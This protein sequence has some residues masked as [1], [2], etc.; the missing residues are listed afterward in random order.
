MRRRSSFGFFGMFGRSFDLR[1]LDAAL[2]GVDLH[3]AL[4][5]E[6]VKMT[7]VNLMKD[8]GVDE[9]EEAYPA[10]AE[11]FG[12]CVMGA[13]AFEAVNGGQRLAAV[14]ARIEKAL[15]AGEGIDAQLILLAVHA[16]LIQPEVIERYGISADE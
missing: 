16:K 13:N 6:G 9:I 12:Y 5:P 10:V 7:M 1:Q 14:E 2:R 15:D 8:H 3:P 4:V 11:M